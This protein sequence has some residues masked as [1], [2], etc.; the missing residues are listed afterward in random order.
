MEGKIKEII[1]AIIMIAIVLGTTFGIFG[2]EY[3]NGIILFV[4]FFIFIWVVFKYTKKQIIKI[5]DP[6]AKKQAMKIGIIILVPIAL[7][8]L[9]CVWDF[10]RFLINK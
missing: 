7:I 5:K 2:D 3:A 4:A 10:L 6:I 8:L 9:K 1:F